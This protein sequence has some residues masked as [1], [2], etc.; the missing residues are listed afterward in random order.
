M[1]KIERLTDSV[2][3]GEAPHWDPEAQTLYYVDI[4]GMSIYQ[5]EPATKKVSKASVGL[6]LV[7]F[8]IPVEGEKNQFIVSLGREIVRIFWNSELQDVRVIE[9][10]AEVEQAPEFFES[11]FNDGKCDPLGRLWAG[12]FN[13][14]SEKPL[15]Y[16]PKGALY[17]LNS[18]RQIQQHLK[19]LRL[20]NGIAFN[21]KLKAMYFIDSGKGTID[22]YDFDIKAGTIS[23]CRAIFTLSKH[24]ISGIADGMTI[25][26][27]GNLWVAIFNGSRIIK[28]DPRKPETLLDSIQMPVKQITSLTFGGP[29]LDE[30]YVT[31]GAYKLE[32]E[33][34]PPPENGALYRIT[35]VGTRGLPAT[36]FRFINI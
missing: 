10:L 25:D 32:N 16:P 18:E 28:I 27:D 4:L 33:D 15:D 7:S 9:Q 5:Y 12:T 11:R 8:I 29:N 2:K 1:V 14:V 31:T 17:S 24:Q 35:G 19:G 34:L 22:Q 21:I 23:K 36:N 6:N 30:L 26:I 3:L 13:T 20:S